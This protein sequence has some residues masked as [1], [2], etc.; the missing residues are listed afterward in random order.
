MEIEWAAMRRGSRARRSP[1]HTEYYPAFSPNDAFVAFTRISGNGNSYSNPQAEVFVVPSGG[2]AAIRSGANDPPA[3]QTSVR[4]PGVT[5][6][7]PKW[8]PAA[9]RASNGTTYYWMTFSSTRRSRPQL[10]VAPMTVDA[11]GTVNAGH[12]A[13]YLWNQPEADNN[14]TPSWDDYRLPPIIVR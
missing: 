2:G 8:S 9:T 12:P 7:W 14:H 10:Y 11:A 3:C 13:L 5:N 1:P 6:S 4:S